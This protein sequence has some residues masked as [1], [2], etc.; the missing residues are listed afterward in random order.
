MMLIILRMSMDFLPRR[1]DAPS[2]QP[3]NIVWYLKT[4]ITTPLGYIGVV[5]SYPQ[6]LT[7]SCLAEGKRM[8]SVHHQVLLDKVSASAYIGC[9]VLANFFIASVHSKPK[10]Y[11][12]HSRETYC[13]SK[14]NKNIECM[15]MICDSKYMFACMHW[16]LCFVCIHEYGA[17][18]G[19]YSMSQTL[20]WFRG[21]LIWVH[22]RTSTPRNLS[23]AT[24]GLYSL[25]LCSFIDIR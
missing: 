14:K 2:H 10:I 8:D 15:H 25:C 13:L 20:I 19:F 9:M 6:S 4:P 17:H 12:N 24:R 5:S 7:V 11:R 22:T 1:I 18:F 16:Q 21:L 3:F 23:D